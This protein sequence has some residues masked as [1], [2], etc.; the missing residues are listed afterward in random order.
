MSTQTALRLTGR[1]SWEQ[2]TAFQEPRPTAG[3]HE[4]LIKVRGVALNFRDIAISTSKYPFKVKDQ[5]VPGS[6]A[7]GDIVSVGEGVTGFS[8]GDKVVVSF[9]QATQYG[10]IKN[11]ENGLGGPI[12]GVLREYISVPAQTVV[13]VPKHSA[14]SYA[15]WASVVCTGVTAWN[16][17]YGVSPIKPGQSVLFQGTG[18][19][20]ITGLIL[21]KA[22]GAKTIITSSSDEKLRYVKEKYG[23]DYTIN[24]KT[25]PDWAA[26]A[27]KIT[28]GQ[29]VDYILENGGSGTM[30][31][32]LEAIAYGGVISVIG[33]LA[34]ASQDEMPD[35]SLLALGKAAIV[36]GIIIGSKQQL[37]EAVL[38]IGEKDLELPVEKTFQFTRDQV[39]E[40][41]SYLTSGQHVGKV[42]I[43]F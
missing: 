29:G 6:D 25:T 39:V 21:A 4:V 35:V 19:V 1:N 13:K 33:F 16:S 23:V 24:Y 43:E 32:S 31:Q 38:F 15:Q 3:K 8:A 40:A 7:A 34:T 11:W 2:L 17:L 36:R 41:Y 28:E 37:E 27:Q 20:S 14:L 42:C 5:V 30:K 12:D 10:P 9:D 22:A 18:G 26:E